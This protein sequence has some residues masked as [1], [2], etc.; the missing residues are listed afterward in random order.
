MDGPARAEQ[1]I[2]RCYRDFDEACARSDFEAAL[3]NLSEDHET[4]FCNEKRLTR[5]EIGES[6]FSLG[7]LSRSRSHH[8]VVKV[9]FRSSGCTV[10]SE[11]RSE[12]TLGTM[13]FSVDALNLDLWKPHQDD[14]KLRRRIKLREIRTSP[15]Q[16]EIEEH[17][18]YCQFG[19]CETEQE[20]WKEPGEDAT[21]G[22]RLQQRRLSWSFQ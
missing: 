12:M 18:L 5:P 8:T 3:A 20:T 6:T 19:A 15:G 21:D 11:Y 10:T 7:G 4:V 14:W 2:R 16:V 13:E 1:T 9:S 17:P 22:S